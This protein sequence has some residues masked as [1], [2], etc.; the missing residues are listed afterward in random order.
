MHFII[1]TPLIKCEVSRH[2]LH[3]LVDLFELKL[4]KLKDDTG[5]EPDGREVIKDGVFR[6]SYLTHHI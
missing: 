1:S 6:P 5:W 2:S 3:F 4:L